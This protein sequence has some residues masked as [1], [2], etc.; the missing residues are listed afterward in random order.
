MLLFFSLAMYIRE[1]VI[2]ALG[3]HAPSRK[4]RPAYV[5]LCAPMRGSP[6]VTPDQTG[7]KVGERLEWLST[8]ASG[9]AACA[10][11]RA[12]LSEGGYAPRHRLRVSSSPT[13]ASLS[14][15]CSGRSM[16]PVWPSA[17]ALSTAPDRSPGGATS[18][19]PS[20]PFCRQRWRS[21]ITPP[22]GRLS[23][24]SLAVPRGRLL[25]RLNR[26][27]DHRG[28]SRMRTDS[29]R[30]SRSSGRRSS[31]PSAM[32][33]ATNWSHRTAGRRDSQGSRP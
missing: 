32:I 23:A 17:E 11:N 31:P 16:K 2:G 4:V 19:R 20:V 27:L 24:S 30:T 1:V 14:S 25:D 26:L 13:V 33:D 5:T 3:T 12:M 10:F 29:R 8:V 18:P 6:V 7:W 21:A 9:D 22:A 28:T 15:V